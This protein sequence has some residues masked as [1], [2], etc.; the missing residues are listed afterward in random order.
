[1][2]RLFGANRLREAARKLST[3]DLRTKMEIVKRWHKDYHYGSLLRDKETSREQQFNQHFF[4]QILG[5]EEKPEKTYSFEPKASALGGQLPDAILGYDLGGK[6]RIVAVVELK[7]ASADLDRPQRRESNLSPVQQ[8]FKYKPLYRNCPFVIV[9]NFFEFRLYGDNQL[10]FES[11]TLDGKHSAPI[12][13]MLD[14]RS[15]G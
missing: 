6:R 4:I 5:Y 14:H 11:W 1:M 2:A 3:E 7:G 10:D 15:A 8:A 13:G 9:S 12:V